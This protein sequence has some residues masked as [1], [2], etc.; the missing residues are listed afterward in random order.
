MALSGI[1]DGFGELDLS[2]L[3]VEWPQLGTPVT[4]TGLLDGFDGRA[5]IIKAIEPSRISVSLMDR[6][7]IVHVRPS[8]LLPAPQL[9]ELDA[10][11]WR[12]IWC[13]LPRWFRYER[14]AAVCAQWRDFAFEDPSL[15]VKLVIV[16]A[17]DAWPSHDGKSFPRVRNGGRVFTRRGEEDE[18][19]TIL[20]YVCGDDYLP[21]LPCQLKMLPDAAWVHTLVIADPLANPMGA[22]L[23]PT[24]DGGTAPEQLHSAMR[25]WSAMEV[26]WTV[27]FPTL[28]AVRLSVE[29]MGRVLGL[30]SASIHEKLRT[31][32][33][34]WLFALP[35]SLLYLAIDGCHGATPV[36]QSFVR[37]LHQEVRGFALQHYLSW[38]PNLQGLRHPFFNLEESRLPLLLPSWSEARRAQLRFIEPGNGPLG[39]LSVT[40]V[41]R[42]CTL[43]PSMQALYWS[44]TH[45]DAHD[46]FCV[47]AALPKSLECL[48]L[49]LGTTGLIS[50]DEWA[51]LARLPNLRKL[52]VN[53]ENADPSGRGSS[54]RDVTAHLSSLLPS[55][56]V[57]VA[58]Q[59]ADQRDSSGAGANVPSFVPVLEDVRGERD[60]PWAELSDEAS[61]LHHVFLPSLDEE[62]LA[63]PRR[64]G[65]LSVQAS[66]ISLHRRRPSMNGYI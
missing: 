54:P 43:L 14:C 1:V 58:C 12:H 51:V 61:V 36:M 5:G 13:F 50:L 2:A 20:Q 3:P 55:A 7:S 46:L 35:P 26:V 19:S 65:P 62:W 22:A 34:P 25:C 63:D 4:L 49:Q 28:A 37:W 48:L 52:L 10:E 40:D 16:L 31:S 38:L 44:A 8:N 42:L 11:L 59:E 33:F 57:L 56:S 17:K 9:P 45:V 24:A 15:W 47:A 32:F 18:P 23:D 41:M 53:I 29:S 39:S 6:A 64:R 21:L 30:G 60:A 27:R 66:Q